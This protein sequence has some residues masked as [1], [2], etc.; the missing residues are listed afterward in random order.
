VDGAIVETAEVLGRAV[1]GV[2]RDAVQDVLQQDVAQY[3]AQDTAN[4]ADGALKDATVAGSTRSAAS[5]GHD[6]SGPLMVVTDRVAND[7]TDAPARVREALEKAFYLGGGRARVVTVVRENGRM[8]P[9][10]DSAFDRRFNCSACGTLFPE[11]TPA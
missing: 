1:Q 2:V 9:V 6:G 8:T 11:P 10:A 4:G 7:S 5:S 3:V